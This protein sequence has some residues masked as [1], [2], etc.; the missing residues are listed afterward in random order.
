M[1]AI[2]EKKEPKKG[3]LEI[4]ERKVLKEYMV[5]QKWRVSEGGRQMNS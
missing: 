3:A 1:D 5:R 4:F 2:Y